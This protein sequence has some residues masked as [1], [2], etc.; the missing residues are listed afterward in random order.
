[1]LM[2]VI[3]TV[4]Y[5]SYEPPCIFFIIDTRLFANLRCPLLLMLKMCLPASGGSSPVRFSQPSLG[6]SFQ[7]T[8]IGCSRP[9][10][11]LLEGAQTSVLLCKQHNL[12]PGWLPHNQ[13][14]LKAEVTWIF[15]FQRKGCSQMKSKNS[16][17]S[18][19]HSQKCLVAVT[20]TSSM[21]FLKF[22]CVTT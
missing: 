19:Q 13:I 22:I 10:F 11:I 3:T 17:Q 6:A 1:M 9:I 12:V 15:T 21:S 8:A 2:H 4:K 14:E 7:I 18:V 16:H 20:N 5:I